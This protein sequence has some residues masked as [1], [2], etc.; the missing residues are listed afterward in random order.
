MW[1]G[2]LGFWLATELKGEELKMH[3]WS[4]IN[5]E[6]AFFTITSQLWSNNSFILSLQPM[7]LTL[8]EMSSETT[9]EALFLS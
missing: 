5:P 8:M 1:R 3:S 6:K 4:F 9:Q 2:D 7:A